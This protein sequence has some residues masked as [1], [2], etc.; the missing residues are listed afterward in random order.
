[1]KVRNL[2]DTCS[3]YVVVFEFQKGGELIESCPLY[4]ISDELM[5]QEVD[6]WSMIFSD[7]SKIMYI[8]LKEDQQ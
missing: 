3:D 2:I 6:N 7:G 8:V 1:M 5:E 4:E